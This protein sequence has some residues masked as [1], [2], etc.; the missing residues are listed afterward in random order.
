[1]RQH[2]ARTC[3][4]AL[5]AEQSTPCEGAP[6]VA[7]ARR[8]VEACGQ[9]ER[10][11]GAPVEVADPAFG[12]EQHDADGEALEGGEERL[13]VAEAVL[14]EARDDRERVEDARDHARHD[15]DRH[16]VDERDQV[17]E[18]RQRL[19]HVVHG[20]QELRERPALRRPD[21][22]TE[23]DGNRQHGRDENL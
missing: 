4:L 8:V 9:P 7:L 5:G 12:R 6:V 18:L 23:P 11:G 21:P 1:M 15:R 2:H 13:D 16:Q 20:P 22:E 10:V 17:D 14:D 19:Q 3:T